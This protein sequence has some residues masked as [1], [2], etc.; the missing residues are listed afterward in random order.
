[1]SYRKKKIKKNRFNQLRY[2]YG[3]VKTALFR[4]MA[5][6]FRKGGRAMMLP[7]TVRIMKALREL[8]KNVRPNNQRITEWV[9][10]YVDRSILQGKR[11]ELFTPWCIGKNLETRLK[12]QGGKFSPISTEIKAFESMARIVEIFLLEGVRVNWL[13]T[14]NNAFFDNAR[15]SNE[16]A[17]AYIE[18]ISQ[19]INNLEV[20]RENILVLEWERDVLG[21]R[22][23]PN[24]SV[25][26]C[27]DTVV[28]QKAFQIDL[29]N[30]IRRT[31]QYQGFDMNIQE[32]ETDVKFN[33]ACEA[34]EGR[35]LMSAESPF[36]NGEFILIPLEFPERIDF[37][38]ILAPGL[39]D[40]VVAVM[41]PYPWRLDAD[42]MQYRV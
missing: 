31:K 37:S 38:S 12:K 35:F 29:A 15:V 18:M 41:K 27:F 17:C 23:L 13:L 14:F 36:T 26:E 42:S 32:I 4:T 9:D 28:P 2:K 30:F 8:A 40:R 6:L 25:L 24:R 39:K 21:G 16:I 7:Q 20:L 10:W 5:S 1:M 33:I 19:L 3:L 22:S 34:E 11:V